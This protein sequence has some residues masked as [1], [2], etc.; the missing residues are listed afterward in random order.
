VRSR[1]S[2]LAKLQRDLPDATIIDVTSKA[3]DPWVRFSPFFPHGGIP[4]PFTEGRTGQSVEGIWQALKV[5]ETVDVDPKKLD[6]TAMKGLKR[7]V[8][9]HGKCLGHREGLEGQRL[10]GY[11]EARRKIYLPIYT[12]VLEHKLTKEL[13][14]LRKHVVRGDVV[15]LDYETNTDITNLHKPLSHAGLVAHFLTGDKR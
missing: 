4:I 12:W 5:F 11:L 13:D 2:S 9:K 6:V 7:T 15:L 10:L 14:Q 3:A 8:R 1:R